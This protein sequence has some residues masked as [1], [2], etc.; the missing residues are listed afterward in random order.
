MSEREREPDPAALAA[1]AEGDVDPDRL[2]AAVDDRRRLADLLEPGEQPHH[3]LVGTILDVVRGAG[4]EE[5]RS[6]RTAPPDG[7]VHAVLTDRRLLVAVSYGDSASTETV[8]LSELTGATVQAAG[9]N[10]RLRLRT[11]DGGYDLYP[12]DRAAAEAAA[13]HVEEHAGT[14][15]D[16]DGADGTDAETGAGTEAGQG[17]DPDP[18]ER[19]ERLADLHERGALTDA[20]FEAKKAE[21]LEDI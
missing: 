5:Q 13:A 7:A 4:D 16:A 2:G 11:A 17:A 3:L 1:R 18:L 8:P 19:L 20:E 12:D 10:T 21:L 14:A 9:A 6:R 15:G